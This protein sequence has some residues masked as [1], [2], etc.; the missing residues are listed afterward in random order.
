VPG[1]CPRELKPETTRQPK[2]LPG[3][4]FQKAFAYRDMLLGREGSAQDAKD[5]DRRHGHAERNQNERRGYPKAAVSHTGLLAAGIKAIAGN[6]KP[7]QRL[8]ALA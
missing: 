1:T 6:S 5:H 3:R 2:D 8:S 7:P 4:L